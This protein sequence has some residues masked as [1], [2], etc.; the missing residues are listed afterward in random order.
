MITFF[1][2]LIHIP[3]S[4]VIISI[5]VFCRFGFCLIAI[6]LKTDISKKWHSLFC[7]CILCVTWTFTNTYYSHGVT[8]LLFMLLIGQ[9]ILPKGFVSPQHSIYCVY[10]YK[11]EEGRANLN[12][13]AEVL[14]QI[15]RILSYYWFKFTQNG[16]A[17]TEP[18]Y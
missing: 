14:V 17:L 12:N 16:L 9:N 8:T 13:L 10:S 7:M 6:R 1:H 4:K 5:T 2:V 18:M 15:I 3:G 11:E